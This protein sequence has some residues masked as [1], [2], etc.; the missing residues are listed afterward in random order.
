MMRKESSRSRDGR[1]GKYRSIERY[2]EREKA[3]RGARG[4]YFV[5]RLERKSQR[6]AYLRPNLLYT[7]K[8]VIVHYFLDFLG[9][10]MGL[11]APRP[12]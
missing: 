5:V 11:L 12:P 1:G 6:L 2:T 10:V 7:R 8:F 3:D 9:G 4:R